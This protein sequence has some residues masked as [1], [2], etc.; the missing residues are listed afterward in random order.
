MKKYN[1]LDHAKE[2]IKLWNMRVTVKPIVIS[3][4]GTVV[5]GLE[6]GLK[7]L[8]IRGRIETN[9]TTAF[10]RSVKILRRDP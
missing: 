2:Q 9:Q 8:E 1:Y 3:A 7:E 4:L 5:K 10:L 6:M